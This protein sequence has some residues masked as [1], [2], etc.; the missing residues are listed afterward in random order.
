MPNNN[1]EDKCEICRGYD[2]FN[3]LV[4]E[5]DTSA[6][7]AFHDVFEYLIEEVIS[8][9]VEDASEKSFEQAYNFGFLDAHKLM[10]GQMSHIV[11]VL[12]ADSDTGH[13][14]DCDCAE[15]Y[16]E[17]EDDG[18]NYKLDELDNAILKALRKD[19]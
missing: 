9:I 1:S 7:E 11:D 18:M 2:Y 17:R 5:T 12:E 10:K 4:N 14:G 8:D 3:F 16:C 19:K 6:E 13:C 15:G